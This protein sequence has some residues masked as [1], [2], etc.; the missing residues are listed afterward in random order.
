MDGERA[1]KSRLSHA[2][3]QHRAALVAI[4]DDVRRELDG[5]DD[6]ELN[7]R[8]SESESANNNDDVVHT[9][10]WNTLAK[11]VIFPSAVSLAFSVAAGVCAR[12]WE[13]GHAEDRNDTMF[14]CFLFASVVASAVIKALLINVFLR[15][16]PERCITHSCFFV[17]SFIQ[18][19][20]EGVA[21]SLCWRSDTDLNSKA[22][23]A[24]ST[25]F[26]QFVALLFVDL[27]AY[28]E[29][30][31][32]RRSNREKERDVEVSKEPLLAARAES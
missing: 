14:M 19:V 4:F 17:F 13:H 30:E 24:G 16:G 15:E 22:R 31:D 25:A 28:V 5:L 29:R 21:F 27:Y 11:R 7:A 3:A 20:L 32:E 10:L 26:M 23:L 2:R 18:T 6:V 12:S 9:G 1:L 8:E